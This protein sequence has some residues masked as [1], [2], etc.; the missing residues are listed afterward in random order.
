MLVDKIPNVRMM[1][2]KCIIA[3]KKLVDKGSEGLII[4][5]RE[6]TDM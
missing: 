4:K 1:T 3:N 2:L 5:M 6:D